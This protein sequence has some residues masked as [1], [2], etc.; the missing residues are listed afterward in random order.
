MSQAQQSG[1]KDVSASSAGEPGDGS[2]G[3]SAAAAERRA[4]PPFAC[5]GEWIAADG[6]PLRRIDLP[7]DPGQPRGSILFLSGRGDF[8]EKYL[9]SLIEWHCAGWQ[10]T[11]FDWRGQGGSGRLGKDPLTGHID[12]FSTW[13]GDLAA[14]WTQWRGQ[15]PGPH[16][17]IAH[18][19][20]GH[21]ALRALVERQIDPAAL[22]IAAPMLGLAGQPLPPAAMQAIARLMMRLG[23]PARPAWKWSDKPGELPSRRTSLLTHD[24]QRYA[25]EPW[26]RAARPQVAM[27]PGSWRWVERAYASMRELDRPGVLEAVDVPVLLLGSRNDKLVSFAAIERAAGRL[28]NAELVAFGEEAHHEILREEDAV[29]GR[30]MVAIGEFLDRVA[31]RG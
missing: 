12:D 25:D 9:E 26:W 17:V 14:F 16:I 24:P 31:P 28:P 2:G 8:Y 21:L 7:G 22:V 3:V 13:V 11:A 1:A 15:T 20:G 23:D 6:W 29:R 30:A 18:S 27:G 19:M 4:I 5:E 10:V